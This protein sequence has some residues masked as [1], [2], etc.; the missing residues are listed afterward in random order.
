MKMI[1]NVST[2]I[3][4]AQIFKV[5]YLYII[6]NP[7]SAVYN[8]AS[9]VNNLGL[10]NLEQIFLLLQIVQKSKKILILVKVFSKQ[11]LLW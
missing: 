9:S 5:L 7:P 4:N 6:F 10:W 3:C 1:R 8:F 2:N 11:F